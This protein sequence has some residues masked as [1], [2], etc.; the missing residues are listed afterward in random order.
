MTET[1]HDTSTDVATDDPDGEPVRVYVSTRQPEAYHL[2]ESCGSL[3]ES[4]K[5]MRRSVARA[6]DTMQV[7]SKSDCAGTAD[8]AGLSKSA[9]CDL[10]GHGGSRLTPNLETDRLCRWCIEDHEKKMAQ[11]HSSDGGV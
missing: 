2:N 5:A 6:W 10:C 11:L 7:C 1:E 3:P 8:S 9:P 4:Y